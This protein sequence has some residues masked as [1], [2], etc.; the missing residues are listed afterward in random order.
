LEAN[1]KAGDMEAAVAVEA[2]D[3]NHKAGDGDMEAAVVAA[4]AAEV[5]EAKRKLNTNKSTKQTECS[6]D[7]FWF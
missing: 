1:K 7:C 4:A 6:L 5:V 2:G 3:G